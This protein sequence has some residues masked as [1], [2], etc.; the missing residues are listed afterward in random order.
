[1]R[2]LLAAVLLLASGCGEQTGKVADPV[3]PAETTGPTTE[4]TITLDD[5]AGPV[6][7]T[8]TCD[9]PGGTHPD[10]LAACAAL[11]EMAAPFA[12]VPKDL[13]CTQVYAG[14]ERAVVTGTWQGQLVQASFKRTDGCEVARWAKHAAVLGSA[15]SSS[16][17]S[18]S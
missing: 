17:A 10:A 13:M 5:G 4:L 6:T 3:T 1:V 16:G 18:S 15:G 14:P 9:P 12:P 8:L 2:T 7:W 11:A